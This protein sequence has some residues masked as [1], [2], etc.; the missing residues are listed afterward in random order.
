MV[1]TVCAIEYWPQHESGM[2]ITPD[3]ERSQSGVVIAVS[4]FKVV[5]MV[6]NSCVL[7]VVVC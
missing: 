6:L 1:L 4:I 3:D 2:A 5:S 7:A